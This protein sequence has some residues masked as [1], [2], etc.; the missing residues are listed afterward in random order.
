MGVQNSD[1][2]RYELRLWFDEDFDWNVTFYLLEETDLPSEFCQHGTTAATTISDLNSTTSFCVQD[3]GVVFENDSV[4]INGAEHV[5]KYG[6]MN[7]S[8]KLSVSGLWN[9]TIQVSYLQIHIRQLQIDDV[10]K[11]YKVTIPH[12]DKVFTFEIKLR[13][14]LC[15]NQNNQLNITTILG[16]D[17]NIT[18]CLKGLVQE[19]LNSIHESIEIQRNAKSK[20]SYSFGDLSTVTLERN[21]TITISN[22]TNEDAGSLNFHLKDVQETVEISVLVTPTA[23]VA[24]VEMEQSSSGTSQATS[25]VMLDKKDLFGV[26]AALCGAGCFIIITIITGGVALRRRKRTKDPP[27]SPYPDSTQTYTSSERSSDTPSSSRHVY[28]RISDII[29]SI[30]RSSSSGSSRSWSSVVTDYRR[31]VVLSEV[32][33]AEYSLPDGSSWDSFSQRVESDGSDGTLKDCWHRD[34][35]LKDCSHR[36]GTLTDGTLRN[37]ALND[38]TLKDGRLSDRTL[39]DGTLRDCTLMNYST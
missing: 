19:N 15:K 11:P 1:F 13:V 6:Q 29:S 27:P 30:L 18:V 32:V 37:V 38:G 23:T 20:I 36:D 12:L 35:T 10:K 2:G 26:I 8:S 7:I 3:Y 39:R 34:G 28:E 16:R 24:T 22:V 21:L 17:E 31:K 33:Y 14:G 4:D 5:V 9:R 25:F